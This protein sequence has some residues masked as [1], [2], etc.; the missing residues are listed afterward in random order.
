VLIVSDAG[1]PDVNVIN[2][3]LAL[4]PI[5][6]LLVLMVVFNWSGARA[7][8][9]AWLVALGVSIL[10]FGG[11][12]DL[13]AYSQV[14]AALLSVWVLYIIWAALLLFHSVD[15]VGSIKTIGQGIARIT[16]NR[17]M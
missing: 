17:V 2:W 7:G 13:I 15:E 10:A 16:S 3:L 12:T 1:I 4:S 11:G 14:K 6:C 8:A 5:G 9:A